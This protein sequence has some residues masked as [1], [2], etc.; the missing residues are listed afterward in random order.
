VAR[1][2][3]DEDVEDLSTFTSHTFV[4]KKSTFNFSRSK[5]PHFLVVT[6]LRQRGAKL[7]A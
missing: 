2:V 5:V 3:D 7:I 1:D 4:I 6:S